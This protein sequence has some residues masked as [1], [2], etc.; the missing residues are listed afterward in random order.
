[1]QFQKL[2]LSL[3]NMRITFYFTVK[4]EKV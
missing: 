1:M 3:Y 2:V 4:Q